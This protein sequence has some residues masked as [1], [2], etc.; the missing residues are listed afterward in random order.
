MSERINR[1]CGLLESRWS[2]VS[3]DTR[4]T[5]GGTSALPSFWA[6]IEYL[7][8]GQRFMEVNHERRR[9]PPELSSTGRNAT[10]KLLL[11][12]RIL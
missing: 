10:A 5:G 7:I 2:P 8:K 1:A 11:H 6:K 12:V 9:G 4:N 3:M